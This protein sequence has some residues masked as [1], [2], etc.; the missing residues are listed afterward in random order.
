[1]KHVILILFLGIN[2][3]LAWSQVG[4]NTETP[5][6]NSDLE[7]ASDD[8][9]FLMNRV[10]LQQTT[11]PTPLNA[12]IEG[13]MVYN[14]IEVNDV[15]IG[16]YYNDGSQWVPVTD[17]STNAISQDPIWVRVAHQNETSLSKFSD[18][19]SSRSNETQ[20]VIKDNGKVG[21]GTSQPNA[22]LEIN[23]NTA[24]VAGLRMS[25]MTSN[26]PTQKGKTIGVNETGDVVPLQRDETVF[27][28]K[29]LAGATV[30][31]GYQYIP[32]DPIYDPE[33]R[34]N[35]TTHK[36]VPLDNSIYELS[37]HLHRMD[38]PMPFNVYRPNSANLI[39][40]PTGMGQY[41]NFDYEGIYARNNPTGR[42]EGGKNLGLYL[43]NNS[44]SPYYFDPNL[45]YVQRGLWTVTI[46]RIA[47]F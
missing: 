13:M 20:L 43:N 5:N 8:K 32:L 46:K 30:G 1:M 18:G 17:N 25:Q 28:G 39:Y 37:V 12:H 14:T 31:T 9:G 41:F 23:S 16:V 26:S 15:K 11:N 27:V 44:G 29:V 22:R 42:L 7:L 10:S 2:I 24:D 21:I 4:V 40:L 6:P 35:S 33:Q 3:N 45:L 47:T 36:W 19:V 38:G 34:Y